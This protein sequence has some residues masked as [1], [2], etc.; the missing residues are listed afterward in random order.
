MPS[1]DRTARV[2]Q[3]LVPARTPFHDA[4]AAAVDELRSYINARRPSADLRAEITSGLGEFAQGRVD[5][6]RFAAL[7]AGNGR[8][9]AD[10]LARLEAAL[11]VLRESVQQGDDLY[12]LTLQPGVDLRDT[13]RGALAARGRVFAAAR[14]AER[15]RSGRAMVTEDDA[16]G[17]AFRH[18]NRAERQIAPPLVIDLQGGDLLAGGLGEY[19][20]G[21]AK[22]VL[23]VHG[24]APAA[25]LARL[26]APHL[27][28]QQAVA[29]EELA[30][31]AASP[32]PGIAALLPEGAARFCHD[33][34]AGTRLGHRLRIDMLPTE[35]PR[36]AIGAVSV[37]QQ[38]YDLQWL[39]ELKELVAAPLPAAAPA[40]PG[41]PAAPADLLAAWLLK[42]TDLTSA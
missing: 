25:P 32:A 33:P 36:Y 20:E 21:R 3:V 8:L 4:V 29:A 19:L 28:V 18:W 42:Q 6:E 10:E 37:A 23:V 22:L 35:E 7:F 27:F 12:R 5:P 41:V 26:V 40:E 31:F 39:R 24:S 16:G 17:F 14:G 11:E 2:M 15:I 30:A 13:V 1:D 38:Q 9:S 34:H